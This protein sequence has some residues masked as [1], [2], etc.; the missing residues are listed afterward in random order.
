MAEVET[1]GE[2]RH[3]TMG[4]L[5][6]LWG[7]GNPVEFPVAGDPECRIRLEPRHDLLTLRAPLEGPEPDLARW[8]HIDIRVVAA[9]DDTVAELTVDVED[10]GVRAAYTLLVGV[11]D[12]LQ[13]RGRSLA[14][15]VNEAIAAQRAV[16]TRRG[17]MS[18][19]QEVGLVGELMLLEHLVGAIG[20]ERA[21]DCWAGPLSEEHDFVFSQVHLEVK[22]TRTEARRHVIHGL[23]QLVPLHNVPLALVS[24]QI[25]VG[26]PGHGATLPELVGR[27]REAVGPHVQSLDD[28]LEAF[29]WDDSEGDLYRTV[30]TL[31]SAPRAYAVEGDFP[32]MTPVALAAVV[33]QFDLVSDVHYRVDV[34]N[35][36]PRDLP[37]PLNGYVESPEEDG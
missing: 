35:L 28:R 20:P 19:D 14:A 7:A 6:Q 2:G 3:L 21:L 36:T 12:E 25:T 33:P 34:S 26:S 15:A 22:T 27:L 5:E 4:N 30:W 11:V 13:L 10:G 17:G 32:A 23:H 24:T 31:R 18:A 1:G 29:A 8:R 16:F 37:D 9:D